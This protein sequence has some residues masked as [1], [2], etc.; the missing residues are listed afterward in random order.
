MELGRLVISR[1]WVCLVQS[2]TLM[3]VYLIFCAPYE[4]GI[5]FRKELSELGLLV[6]S[7]TWVCLEQPET[8]SSVYL[9]ICAP[10]ETGIL[11][12]RE[13]HGTGCLRKHLYLGLSCAI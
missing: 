11:F 2:E 4:T 6:N 3:S 1:T 8:I 7:I 10:Y 13:L 5:L 12:Y 9:M